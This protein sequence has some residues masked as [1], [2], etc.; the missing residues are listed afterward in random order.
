ME[1]MS[2]DIGLYEIIILKLIWKVEDRR[3]WAW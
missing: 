2:G 3:T 1:N